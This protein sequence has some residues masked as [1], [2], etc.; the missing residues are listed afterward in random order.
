MSAGRRIQQLSARSSCRTARNLKCFWPLLLTRNRPRRCLCCNRLTYHEITATRDPRGLNSSV[1]SRDSQYQR[2]TESE[3]W[4]QV[5]L[6][7]QNKILFH[8]FSLSCICIIE[9]PQWFVDY[10]NLITSQKF[11]GRNENLDRSSYLIM[12]LSV[13]VI[14]V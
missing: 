2:T 1:Y 4:Y 6:E 7:S 14:V 11:P 13:F 3:R 12:W 9:R 10:Q 8:F 5:T